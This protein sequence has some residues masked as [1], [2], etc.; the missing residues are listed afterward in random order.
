MAGQ[1]ISIY[2]LGSL[3]AAIPITSASR[4]WRGRPPGQRRFSDC[5]SA[6]AFGG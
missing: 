3:L 6:R 4:N 1:L 5:I 2:A